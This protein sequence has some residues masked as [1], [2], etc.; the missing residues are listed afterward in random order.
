VAKKQDKNSNT[1][2]FESELNGLE[3]RLYEVTEEEV[4]IIEGLEK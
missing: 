3:F 1:T 4:R 2:A